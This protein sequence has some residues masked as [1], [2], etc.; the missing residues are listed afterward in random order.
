M[1]P[2]RWVDG[3]PQADLVAPVPTPDED[4]TLDLALADPGWVSVRRT[5]AE[6]ARVEADR[7][8]ITGD[9][10]GLDD[11]RPWFLGRRLR[12]MTATV[13]V[14]V[15]ATG[16][17]GGLAARHDEVHFFALEADGDGSTTTVTARAALAGFERTWRAEFPA[18]EVELRMELLRPPS[19]FVP[20]AA[21]GGTVRLVAAAGGREVVLAEFDGRYWSFEVAKSFTG[22]VFGV[23]AADGTVTFADLRYSGTDALPG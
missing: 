13:S 14:R 2:V 4:L 6:V 5:P 20:A 23:Y 21:G 22:R 12:H 11:V 19:G 10:R 8:V 1:A 17:R 9:G 7:L 16:G 15:D 3:W 18:G